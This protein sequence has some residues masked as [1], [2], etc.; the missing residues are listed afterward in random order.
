[1]VDRF[2]PKPESVDQLIETVRLRWLGERLGFEKIALKNGHMKC[3]FLPSDNERYFQSPVFGQVLAFVQGNSQRCKMKEYKTRLILTIQ[4]V[5]S[6]RS[7]IE[8][9]QQV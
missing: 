9:L 5:A 1:M 3:Y 4:N 8:L 7:G 6:V 2:G